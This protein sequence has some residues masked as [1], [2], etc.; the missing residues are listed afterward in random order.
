M[1]SVSVTVTGRDTI[2]RQFDL[3]KLRNS[4]WT[5]ELRRAKS[6]Y[7]R[8]V[9]KN[10]DTE[11]S[12]A[13]GPWKE[14]RLATASERQFQGYPAWNPILVRR[15]DLRWSAT[16]ASG[17]G[18]QIEGYHKITHKKLKM[19]L[20]GDKVKHQFGY[21]WQRRDGK[22]YTVPARPFWDFEDS[23]QNEMF[24]PFAR[25]ASHWLFQP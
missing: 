3:F 6:A 5:P 13:S 14:L 1:P 8:S 24:E 7:L 19:V 21:R 16:H 9:E 23:N 20:R 22:T 25:W 17:V 4:D 2:N 12:R 10:F 18:D 15:G 11:S